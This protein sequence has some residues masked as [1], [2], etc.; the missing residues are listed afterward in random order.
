MSGWT[1]KSAKVFSDKGK[2]SIFGDIA[3]DATGVE[4]IGGLLRQ[5]DSLRLPATRR[6]CQDSCRP[7]TF[8][9]TD[10]TGPGRG[11]LSPVSPPT[12][13]TA[14]PSV[15]RSATMLA[16]LA[17]GE[18]SAFSRLAT[19]ADLAPSPRGNWRAWR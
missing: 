14:S 18:I 11:T 15:G 3:R 2:S 5:R 7:G 12:P 6:R 9:R 10:S 4:P 13:W 19:D 8:C 16:V 17:Y 1:P